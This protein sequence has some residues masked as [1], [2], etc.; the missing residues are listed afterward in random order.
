MSTWYIVIL[1]A[2]AFFLVVP[3]IGAFA[4]RR[5]WRRF[6]SGVVEASLRPTVTYATLARLRRE[7]PADRRGEATISGADAGMFRFFGQLEAIEDDDVIWLNDGTIS[8]A[9][10]VASKVAYLLP[11]AGAEAGY[12][13]TYPEATPDRL[14]W[15]RLTSLPERTPVFVSGRLELEGGRPVFRAEGREG[16]LLILFEGPERELLRHSVWTGRQRNEYWNPLT[17]V[18]LA[19][20]SLAL[21]LSAFFLF[22][23]PADRGAAILSASAALA[24]LLPFL[25]PGFVTFPLY[26]RLWRY[27]RFL[28]AERDLLRLPTR[29]D[30]DDQ[31]RAHLPDGELYLWRE[32]DAGAA[33]TLATRGARSL[34]VT[35]ADGSSVYHAFG[36]PDGE[37]LGTPDDPMSEFVVVPGHPDELARTSQKLAQRYELGS[38][39]LLLLGVGVNFYILLLLTSR[40]LF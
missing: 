6:R 9:A 37:E 39:G 36:V 8:V 24:P 12:G 33:D 14:A 38:L 20:G 11:S 22:R 15:S 17:P 16:L 31:G 32:V 10:D 4:V 30:F 29:H 1:I 5:Q 19:V 18:S 27:G 25:P 2:L 40:L 34:D 3:G 23:L 26:R 28:R 7:A 13:R 21:L 35:V